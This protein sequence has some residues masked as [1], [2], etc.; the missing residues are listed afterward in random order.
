MKLD[1]TNSLATIQFSLSVILL[2]PDGPSVID[3][4]EDVTAITLCLMIHVNLLAS[5]SLFSTL[6]PDLL[7]W[8]SQQAQMTEYAKN[9]PV[10]RKD[11]QST[12]LL[13]LLKGSLMAMD[14][15]NN[16]QEV[17]LHIIAPGHCFGELSAIDGLPRAATVRAMETS[18]VGSISKES[19][20]GII[21]RSPRIA[22]SLLVQF[23]GIIRVNN[24][25]RVILSINNVQR[26]VAALLLSH[27][28]QENKAQG[29]KKILVI[30]KLP[31]QQELAAMANTSRES[32]SRV[33]GGLIEQGLIIR[34]GKELHIPNPDALNQL[35]Q[36]EN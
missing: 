26:R 31:T 29:S 30:R 6:N 23:A 7:E 28:D 25:R 12:D 20:A 18:L 35:I 24:K 34:E 27:S 2:Y 10:I 3:L 17:G 5:V 4:T 8:L 11:D 16:G 15:T 21:E 33:L 14:V 22:Q 19:L 36:R 13:F 32:V 9:D 1:S